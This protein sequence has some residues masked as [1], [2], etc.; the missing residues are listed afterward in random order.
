MKSK[1]A[2]LVPDQQGLNSESL[3]QRKKKGTIKTNLGME[4]LYPDVCIT[5]AQGFL[6]GYRV[7]RQIPQHT[8]TGS[9]IQQ[10]QEPCWRTPASPKVVYKSKLLITPQYLLQVQPY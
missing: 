9:S 7:T 6:F 10:G 8:L 3:S 1:C 5:H 4:E 2:E